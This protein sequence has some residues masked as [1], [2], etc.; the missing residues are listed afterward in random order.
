MRPS[1]R[2][3]YVL[4]VFVVAGIFVLVLH[5]CQG[6]TDPPSSKGAGPRGPLSTD[7]NNESRKIN[8]FVI[9]IQENR[10]FDTY[11]GQLSAYWAANGFPSQQFDG[12]PPGASNPGCNPAASSPGLCV[13]DGNGPMIGSFHWQNACMEL[14]SPEWNLSHMDLNRFNPTGGTAVNDGF[15]NSAAQFARQH[16]LRDVNGLRAMG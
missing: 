11:F 13:A 4:F 1:K 14:I 9:F 6:I 7:P 3:F 12:M 5:G 2:F 16:G 8:H 15:V 10:S